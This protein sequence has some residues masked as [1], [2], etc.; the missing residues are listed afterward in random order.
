VPDIYDAIKYDLLH[1]QEIIG[2]EEAVS[3]RTKVKDLSDIILPLE[4]GVTKD[5]KI[6]VGSAICNSLLKKIKED[7]QNKQVEVE[8]EQLDSDFRLEIPERQVRT[9]VYF[10]SGNT[11]Q[12]LLQVLLNAS[13]W[14]DSP[15]WT[16]ALDHCSKVSEIDFLSQIVMQMYEDSSKDVSSAERWLV[17]IH[18]SPGVTSKNV[19]DEVSDPWIQPLTCLHN[20]LSHRQLDDFLLNITK[21]IS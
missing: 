20:G 21:E 19:P 17:Q 9:R 7:F 13:S 11:L 10:T 2:F 6:R 8:T 16:D 1:N 15:Q 12:G 14:S 5:E 3:L 18:F 4:N